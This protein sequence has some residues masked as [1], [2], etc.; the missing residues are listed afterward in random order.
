M[1]AAAAGLPGFAGGLPQGPMP[2][3]AR[4][5]QA[6]LQ[7]VFP[8]TVFQHEIV[9]A[10]VNAREWAK[11]VR[12]TPFVGVGWSTVSSAG[13]SALFSGSSTWTIFLAVTNERGIAQRYYGDAQAPGLFHLVQIAIAA[14]NGMQARDANGTKVGSVVVKRA[15]NAH[16]ENF[17]TNQAIAVIDCDVSITMEPPDVM[18]A[19]GDIGMFQQIAA[20]WDFGGNHGGEDVLEDVAAVPTQM[21][22][23]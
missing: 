9:P 4:S 2:A 12:R 20:T 16:G 13:G 1:S 7:E 18:P 22:A 11:L 14:V 19:P 3:I 15:S 17:D 5:L 6:R 8:L 10:N 21:G 23:S